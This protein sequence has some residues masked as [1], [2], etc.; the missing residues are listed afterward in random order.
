M[1]EAKIHSGIVVNPREKT[2]EKAINIY[3]WRYIC[4]GSPRADRREGL[5]PCLLSSPK[6]TCLALV[7]KDRTCASVLYF[8]DWVTPVH[9][10]Q[11]GHIP[12]GDCYDRVGALPAG[13]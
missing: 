3:I 6:S 10:E 5:L 13:G 9:L 8:M 12:A 11:D 7:A 1:S 4:S 2:A